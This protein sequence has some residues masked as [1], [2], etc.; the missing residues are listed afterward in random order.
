M[1]NPEQQRLLEQLPA[2]RGPGRP[3]SA[4]PVTLAMS[5]LPL[6]ADIPADSCHFGFVPMG[7]IAR[8]FDMKEAAH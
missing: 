6:E 5:E 3:K 1:P 8:W 4:T 2:R 7:D